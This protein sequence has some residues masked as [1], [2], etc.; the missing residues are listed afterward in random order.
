PCMM[1]VGRP[2]T[3]MVSGWPPP[4][5]SQTRTPYFSFLRRS[6]MGRFSVVFSLVSH[7]RQHL[8]RQQFHTFAGQ[9]VGQRTRLAAGQYHA[10][11]Q[12]FLVMF[13]FLPDRGWAADDG[14]NAL[15]HVLP[16]L[17]GGQELRVVFDDGQRGTRRSV[18]RRGQANVLE[19]VANEVPAVRLELFAGLPVGLC[20]VNWHAPA[21]LFGPG[22]VAG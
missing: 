14:E 6:N 11:P 20:D 7:A 19:Q 15:L 8:P 5:E 1:T 12:L 2:A 17:L 9:F 21:H 22:L 3:S 13:Q 16:G 4:L 10:D 18:T